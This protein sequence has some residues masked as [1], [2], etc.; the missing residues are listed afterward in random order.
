MHVIII[1]CSLC[2]EKTAN[3]RGGIAL[4][5]A[6]AGVQPNCFCLDGIRVTGDTEET[7]GSVVLGL[8]A[9]MHKAQG[10]F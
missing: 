2:K 5:A 1:G 4:L 10:C 6:C 8:A 9:A 7:V 3:P